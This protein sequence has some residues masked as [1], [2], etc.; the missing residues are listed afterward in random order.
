MRFKDQT[1]ELHFSE[2]GF[3]KIDHFIDDVQLKLLLDLY[4]K[5]GLGKTN[6]KMYTNLQDLNYEESVAIE[7]AIIK[8]C[9]KSVDVYLENYRI[10]NAGFLIKGIGKNSDSRLHQDWSIVDESKFRS[11]LLWIPLID[12]DEKNGCIQV[13]PQSHNWFQTIRSFSIHSLFLKFNYKIN[14]FLKALPLKTGEAVMFFSKLFHGSK[15]NYSDVERP[16]IT[17]TIIDENADFIH[18]LK[19]NESTIKVL[20]CTKEFIYQYSFKEKNTE[21]A[22]S[23]TL[24]KNIEN[25]EEYILTDKLFLKRLYIEKSKVNIVHRLILKIINFFS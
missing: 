25:P 15:Q 1:A 20:S 7:E 12:V 23:L 3:V 18:Y 2:Q 13:I 4:Y 8:I 24:L 5:S 14:P 10:I 21:N 6:G 16:C 17:I 19:S 22:E 11:A 9:T